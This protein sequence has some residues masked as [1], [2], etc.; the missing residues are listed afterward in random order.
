ME[1]KDK[2]IEKFIDGLMSNDQLETTSPN[3][4]TDVLSKI[5]YLSAS[6][7]TVYKPLIPKFVWWILGLGLVGLFVYIFMVNPQGDYSITE[8]I[9]LS[10]PEFNLFQNID[11][12]F[13]KTL[14]YAIVLLAIMLSVQIP[15][16]KHY[17]NRRL[18]Y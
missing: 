8:T 13:S 14:V 3:F 5:E 6:K 11:V 16:L 2:H 10:L 17:V 15:L 7:T 9:G 4:T 18:G 12:S 1:T